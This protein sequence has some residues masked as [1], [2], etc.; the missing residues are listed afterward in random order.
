MHM[1][2]GKS[3]RNTTEAV[4]VPL[5]FKSHDRQAVD[6]GFVETIRQL[7]GDFPSVLRACP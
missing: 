2:F 5:Y 7:L 1:W 3:C 4:K 6:A